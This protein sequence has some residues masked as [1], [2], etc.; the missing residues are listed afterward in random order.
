[1]II[2][3]EEATSTVPYPVFMQ[4]GFC[5]GRKSEE[6]G[7]KPSKIGENQQQTKTTRGSEPE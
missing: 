7:E 5:G 6:L 4:V 2:F 3:R 1:M